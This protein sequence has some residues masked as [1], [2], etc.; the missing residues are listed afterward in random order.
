MG[1]DIRSLFAFI[2]CLFLSDH[3]CTELA[4]LQTQNISS[5]GIVLYAPLLEEWMRR[6]Y[7]HYPYL[8]V[9]A[10]G[11]TYLNVFI[12]EKST[13][14]TLIKREGHIVGVA[15]GMPFDSENLA[16]FFQAPLAKLAEER[17]IYPEKLYYISFFL[18]APDCRNEKAI[19]EAIYDA[20][21]T[22]AK[23][24]NKTQICFWCSLETAQHPLKPNT[25]TPVEPWG[26]TIKE[27]EPMHI[28][29]SLPWS[30][31][32]IDGSVKEE[33]HPVQFFMKSL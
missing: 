26:Y 31:L 13:L 22:Y 10:E 24:L 2:M 1:F 21:A 27:Y 18:T 9:P 4:M 5:E 11:E 8:W 12:N 28:E 16:Q 30:T 33:A 23:S 20:Q 14:L 7:I 29:L 6:D 3:A 19:V 32:Q 25:P 15:A 17:G